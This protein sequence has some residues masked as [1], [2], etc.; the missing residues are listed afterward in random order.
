MDAL[1]VLNTHDRDNLYRG[2]RDLRIEAGSVGSHV[3]VAV[4]K[5]AGGSAVATTNS[6]T[7]RGKVCGR[8]LGKAFYG[9]FLSTPSAN[10]LAC[11]DLCRSHLNATDSTKRCVNWAFWSWG[12][13][14]LFPAGATPRAD[15]SAVYGV[16]LCGLP[17]EGAIPTATP[18]PAPAATPEQWTP[19]HAIDGDPSTCFHAPGGQAG[20]W[21]LVDLGEMVP[22]AKLVL[23]TG[24]S[25]VIDVA[26]YVGETASD[27]TVDE[28]RKNHEWY[29]HDAQS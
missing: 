6:M 26:F 23:D 29:A 10:L 12:L 15:G 16:P 1:R 22:I 11:Q 17:G 21:L 27:V 9:E 5:G 3:N 14:R 13:C 28:P 2:T 7:S 8:V 24:E 18:R 20:T 4:A 19:G 25:D